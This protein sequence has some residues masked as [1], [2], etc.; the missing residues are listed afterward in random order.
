MGLDELP[1]LDSKD[2]SQLST[3][4]S[5]EHQ[6]NGRGLTKARTAAS[7]LA[8]SHSLPNALSK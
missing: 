1:N 8:T 6:E 5:V 2:V 4:R 3:E 7:C